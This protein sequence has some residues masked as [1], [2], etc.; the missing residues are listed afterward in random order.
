MLCI[1]ECALYFNCVKESVCVCVRGPVSLWG[2]VL[3]AYML[4]ADKYL[5]E[6]QLALKVKKSPFYLLVQN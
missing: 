3:P 6:L 2:S 4:L 5:I 1:D